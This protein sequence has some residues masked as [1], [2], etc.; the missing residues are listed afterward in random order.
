[1]HDKSDRQDDQILVEV[2]IQIQP[3]GGFK[4][5]HWYVHLCRMPLLVTINPQLPSVNVKGKKA[6]CRLIEIP[7]CKHHYAAYFMIMIE[8]DS[9]NS[10]VDGEWSCEPG[11]KVS[12]HHRYHDM[13]ECGMVL[14]G[15]HVCWR[16]GRVRA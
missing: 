9:K 13:Y 5:Y 14:L 3:I 12:S 16:A 8:Q 6:S 15:H 7:T 2:Q 11:V 4:L 10:K 1:M